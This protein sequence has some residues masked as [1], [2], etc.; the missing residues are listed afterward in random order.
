MSL[1]SKSRLTYLDLFAGAGGLSEGFASVGYQPIA[2]VEMDSDACNTLRTRES[3]YYLK[4]IGLSYKYIDYLKND[5]SR[6][7]LYEMIPKGIL[8]SVVCATMSEEIMPSVFENIDKAMMCREIDSVDLILGG[9]PCQAYSM[10]GRA[11]KNMDDDPRN[12]LYKL[13]FIAI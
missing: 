12:T 8:N 2:H 3:Y 11:R 7:Q 10:V 4:S 9:P 6:D 5:L 1:Y 13:Y